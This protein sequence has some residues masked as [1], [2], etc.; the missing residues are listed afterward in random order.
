MAK[1]TQNDWQA[2]MDA[3]TMASYQE[4]ISDKTR[5]NKAIKVAKAKAKDLQKRA[6]IMS[7][8]GGKKK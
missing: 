7:K 2:E 6:S 3:Q 1:K 4:I 8:V 5:M